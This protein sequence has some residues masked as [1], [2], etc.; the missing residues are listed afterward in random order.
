VRG[1]AP[2]RIKCGTWLASTW[3]ANG[4]P[5][6]AIRYRRLAL[7]TAD[8][9]DAGLEAT[10]VKFGRTMASRDL[11][12][13][14]CTIIHRNFGSRNDRARAHFVRHEEVLHPLR[15][16]AL[17]LRGASDTAMGS[18]TERLQLRRCR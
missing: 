15:Q 5:V 16:C 13:R 10:K 1:Q 12:P 8:K 6:R 14:I 4:L 17:G 9:A 3:H 18:P 7:A 11:L 2:V